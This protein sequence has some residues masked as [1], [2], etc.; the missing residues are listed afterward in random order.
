MFTYML[1][2]T[3]PRRETKLAARSIPIRRLR[4][5]HG[6]TVVRRHCASREH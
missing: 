1:S 3:W 6:T 2:I 4:L 5:H